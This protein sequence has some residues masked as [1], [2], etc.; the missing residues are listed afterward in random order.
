[1]YTSINGWE[2]LNRSSTVRSALLIRSMMS[3][4]ATCPARLDVWAVGTF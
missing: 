1:M 3:S 4:A 2:V